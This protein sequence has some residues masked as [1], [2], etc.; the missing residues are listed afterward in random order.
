MMTVLVIS[1][2]LAMPGC[3]L[4]DK[5]CTL[6]QWAQDVADLNACRQEQALAG[7]IITDSQALNDN[8]RKDRDRLLKAGAGESKVPY[9]IGGIAAG[10]ALT[11]LAAILIH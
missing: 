4:D 11:L 2:M 5:E 6:E 3:A 8:L 7:Q 1:S 10:V 9:V